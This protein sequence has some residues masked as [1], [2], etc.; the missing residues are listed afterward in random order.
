MEGYN[1]LLFF[2]GDGKPILIQDAVYG[3][4]KGD[5]SSISHL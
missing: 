2:K 1:L 3:V 5:E 4:C